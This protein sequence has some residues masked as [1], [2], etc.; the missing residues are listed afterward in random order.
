MAS[1]AYC[2]QVGVNPQR[3]SGPQRTVFAGESTQRY[4]RTPKTKMCWAAFTV[5]PTPFVQQSRFA[6][7]CQK[8]L[9][10]FGEFFIRNGLPGNQHE[11]QRLRQLMLM[12][13][14][15]LA[16][17]PPGAVAHHCAT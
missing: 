17:Q 15:R 14:E 4:R 7:G 8:I 3:P 9:F 11:V 13:A 12:K 16:Q 6:Q 1:R 5:S 10:D 2:E